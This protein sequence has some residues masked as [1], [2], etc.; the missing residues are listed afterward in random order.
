MKIKDHI[1]HY[2]SINVTIDAQIYCAISEQVLHDIIV[3]IGL[4]K[5][6]QCTFYHGSMLRQ[7]IDRLV[8]SQL[9]IPVHSCIISEMNINE[10]N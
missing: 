1:K 8:T 4:S 7:C 6:K 10:T 9:H 5:Y 2:N 3:K